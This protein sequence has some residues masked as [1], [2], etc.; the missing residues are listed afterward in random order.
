MWLTWKE[1]AEYMVAGM[2]KCVRIFKDQK[3]EIKVKF[4]LKHKFKIEVWTDGSTEPISHSSSES[5]TC[6]IGEIKYLGHQHFLVKL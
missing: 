6:P 4:L 3:Q 1:G 2:L 5:Q